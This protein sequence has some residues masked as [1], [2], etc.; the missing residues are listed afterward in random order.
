MREFLARRFFCVGPCEFSFTRVQGAEKQGAE[1][2]SY[3]FSLYF[4][5]IIKNVFVVFNGLIFLIAY[6]LGSGRTVP[7]FSIVSPILVFSHSYR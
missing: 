6:F 2:F 5:L 4:S 7:I 3:R 1:S